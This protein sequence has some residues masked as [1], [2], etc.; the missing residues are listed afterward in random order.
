MCYNDNIKNNNNGE[1]N[2]I[3]K[4]KLTIKHLITL[5]NLKRLGNVARGFEITR[6]NGFDEHNGYKT[7]GYLLDLQAHGVVARHQTN[8]KSIW[9]VM[10]ETAPRKS[11]DTIPATEEAIFTVN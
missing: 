2:M 8:G 7:F 3:K 4:P 10:L 5:N 1:Y 9:F 6:L 11:A